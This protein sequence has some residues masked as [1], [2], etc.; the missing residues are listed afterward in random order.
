MSPAPANRWNTPA[1][2]DMPSGLSNP[3]AGPANATSRSRPRRSSSRPTASKTSGAVAA[4]D[5]TSR[6]MAESVDNEAPGAAVASRQPMSYQELRCVLR[7]SQNRDHIE[8][9][10]PNN[11]TDP[12]RSPLSLGQCLPG[13]SD[14]RLGGG[15]SMSA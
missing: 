7:H 12:I 6:Q 9:S 1:R 4:I 11:T 10:S 5:G 13:L 14:I 3:A 8:T 2:S 15:G